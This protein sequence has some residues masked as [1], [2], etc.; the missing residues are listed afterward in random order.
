MN[1]KSRNWVFTWNNYPSDWWD[2]LDAL[3]CRYVVGGKEVGESGTRHIQGL[4][5]F[6]QPKTK[7]TVI[8]YLP[9][10]HIEKCM[11]TCPQAAAYCKKDGDFQEKGECPASPRDSGDGERE[12]WDR[13]LQLA[14][15]GRIAEVDSD[16]QIRYYSSLNRIAADHQ[17]VIQN[18]VSPCGLWI[19]GP[20]G[21]GKSTLARAMFP[22]HYPKPINKWW[23]G[24]RSEDAVII[25]DV[26]PSHASWIAYF[27]K[28]W[29]DRY[30]FIAEIKGRSRRIRPR[31]IVVTSQFAIS[32]VFTDVQSRDAIGRRFQRFTFTSLA[33]PSFSLV[34]FEQ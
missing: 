27:L 16:I 31:A 5:C 1:Q 22:I 26:D 3:T 33:L 34:A 10:C 30:P 9:G 11:G 17:P 18:L 19:V 2:R 28:I 25:D 13:A 7:R 6:A 4:I 12:R 24:Y 21:C 20:S 32:E 23:D 29:G 15:E 14:R 8:G